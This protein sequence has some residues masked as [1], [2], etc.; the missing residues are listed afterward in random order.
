MEGGNQNGP[1]FTQL[2]AMVERE[3]AQNLLALGRQRDEDLAAIVERMLT[4]H[5]SGGREPVDE[6]HR[7]VMFDLE[8]LGQFTNPWSKDRRKSLQRQHELM[9]LRLQAGVTRRPLAKMEKSADLI[10]NL[11]QGLIICGGSVSCDRFFQFSISQYIYR[12]TI[13]I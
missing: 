2:R 9:L 4:A 1:A 3:L 13:Y 6:F 7:T 12:I 11:R 5:Q 8:P 10:A